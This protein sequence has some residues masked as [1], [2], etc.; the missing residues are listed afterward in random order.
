MPKQALH[1]LGHYVRALAGLAG[2]RPET[3]QQLLRRFVC[4]REEPAFTALVQRHGTLVLQAA[5]RV[6]GDWHQAEEVFQATFL[7]LARKAGT[8]R[9]HE[10]LA[11]WLYAVAYRLALRAQARSAKYLVCAAGRDT[12]VAVDPLDALSARE[13]LAVLDMAFLSGTQR[14]GG[15]CAACRSK[16]TA[17]IPGYFL[18]RDFT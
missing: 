15:S 8:I 4:G 9:Q 12:V 10:A 3:D 13:F 7:T 11:S 14:L 17:S 1:H 2:D 16:R 18:P 5:W 6:L